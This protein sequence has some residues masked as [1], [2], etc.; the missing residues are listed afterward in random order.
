MLDFEL[1]DESP[2]MSVHKQAWQSLRTSCCG[3]RLDLLVLMHTACSALLCLRL[4]HALCYA[5]SRQCCKPFPSRRPLTLAAPLLCFCSDDLSGD[6]KLDEDAFD[7]EDSPVRP[8][9]GKRF[10]NASVVRVSLPAALRSGGG[11][12]SGGGRTSRLVAPIQQQQQQQQEA[13]QEQQQQQAPASLGAATAAGAGPP[14][15]PSSASG[16]LSSGGAAAAPAPIPMPA[17]AQP[18]A[19]AALAA[20]GGSGAGITPRVRGPMRGRGAVHPNLV[21]L[22]AHHATPGT[23]GAAAAAAAGGGAAGARS[24][25]VVRLRIGGAGGSP[26]QQQQQQQQ[27]P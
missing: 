15:R 22:T 14:S 20:A 16:R 21:A 18:P 12:A 7:E 23:G 6:Y 1:D 24:P 4:R 9:A 8:P 11:D 3:C 13:Q 2:G 5:L 17:P 10:R 27:Q 25:T 26:A 19:V